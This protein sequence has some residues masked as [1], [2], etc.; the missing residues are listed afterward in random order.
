MLLVHCLSARAHFTVVFT[1]LTLDVDDA[2]P[3][4]ATIDIQCELE[5]MRRLL[6]FGESRMPLTL[7]P[8]PELE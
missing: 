1:Q 5:M 3:I 2:C 7:N 6:A 8:L 4:I